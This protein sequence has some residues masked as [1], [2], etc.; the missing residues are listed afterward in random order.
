MKGDAVVARSRFTSFVEERWG[1]LALW[2]AMLGWSATVF[3]LVRSYFLG[4]RFGRYD[5]GNMVQA[6]WSTAHGRPLETTLG[7]GEQVSRLAAHAD[8]IL[9]ALAPLW[10]LAPSPLTLAAVQ[11]GA[12]ALGALPVFWLGRRHLGCQNAALLLALAYLSYPWLIWTA[13][14]AM[15][16]VT[17]AIPIFLYAIWF[18]DVDRLWAFAVCAVLV[19]GTGELMGLALAGLGIWYWLARGRR[20]AGLIIA[21]AGLAWTVVAVK[22]IIPIFQG[23][24]SPFYSYYEAVGGS[25]GGVV[26]TL[27]T[28][29]AAIA[30]A[31]GTGADLAYVFALS[32]PLAG[33]F[34]LAPGLAAATLPQLAA[35]GLSSIAAAT[36]PRGHHIAGIIPFLI[37]G[38]I[39]GIARLPSGRRMQAA[40]AVLV[41]CIGFTVAFGPWPAL[42]QEPLWPYGTPTADHAEAL[43]N[44]V[45]LVPDGAPVAS[46]NKAGAHLS[47]RRYFYSIP[48]IGKAS[49][50]V[51]DMRDAWVP[52]RPREP[53]RTSWGREDSAL[54]ASFKARIEQSADWER[55][56]DAGGVSLF[57]RVQS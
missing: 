12:C 38:T 46:T 28:D 6:V 16:P 19:A 36:D 57:R 17:L 2:I 56:S 13:L 20:R 5:L 3:A 23:G 34:L 4:F 8:P 32:F 39:L 25:P 31:I 26:R 51:I 52:L 33:A 27:F 37:A 35:N 15:H 49:W 53:I 54:L 48:K 21:A 9:V 40:S 1:E 10:L 30:R 43:R 41:L 29:P 47:A 7:T 14:D 22:V 11:I 55:I 24:D 45:A 50:L 18:L 42:R 44:A